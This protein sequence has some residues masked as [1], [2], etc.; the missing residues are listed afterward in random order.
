MIVDKKP[1][2][3]DP[4]P[5]TSESGGAGPSTST[6]TR[7]SPP[8]IAHCNLL[9]VERSN[10]KVN[11]SYVVDPSIAI[12]EQFLQPLREDE[13][14][15]DGR[16]ANLR[17]LSTYGRIDADVWLLDRS[18]E[19]DSKHPTPN[20]LV[21]QS[22][23]GA[24]DI[25]LHNLGYK[26]PCN[27]TV[28]STYG[29]T[30]VQLPRD[31]VGKVNIHYK[32]GS[33]APLSPRVAMLSD[34]NG[35]RKCFVGDLHSIS[36]DG[37]TGSSIDITSQHGKIKV[38]FAGDRA[39]TKNTSSSGGVWSWLSGSR[40]PGPSSASTPTTAGTSVR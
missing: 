20:R 3:S 18:S 1:V 22:T 38:T 4:P 16:R 34:V 26:A 7:T 32:H 13:I 40:P 14:A 30:T 31:Y 24:V 10:E 15:D 37:W 5:Y 19:P 8:E 2:T 27:I 17:L 11:G 6:T 29:A 36:E 28:G 21:F 39:E 9:C 33:V 25:R 23:H 12:P 35:E